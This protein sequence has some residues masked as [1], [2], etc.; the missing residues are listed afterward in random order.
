MGPLHLNIFF[1]RAKCI[2][3]PICLLSIRNNAPQVSA[4][5]NILFLIFTTEDNYGI[6]RA[7]SMVTFY[8][9]IKMVATDA[10]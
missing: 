9:M 4:N 7:E 10:F 6:A 5:Q 1:W 2:F 3:Q 8:K